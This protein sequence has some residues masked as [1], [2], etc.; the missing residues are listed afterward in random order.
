MILLTNVLMIK[1]TVLAITSQVYPLHVADTQKSFLVPSEP[2]AW[3]MS[4]PNLGFGCD[5][6]IQISEEILAKLF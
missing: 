3:L 4:R 2:L 6:A 5:M 1:I